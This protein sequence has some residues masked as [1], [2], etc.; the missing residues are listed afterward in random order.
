MGGLLGRC[1]WLWIWAL[2]VF[3]AAKSFA[4]P[5]GVHLEHA[6]QLG[7]GFIDSE[8]Q[9]AALP[10]PTPGPDHTVYGYLAYWADDLDTVPWDHLS[11]IAL[12]TAGTTDQGALT[13]TSRWGDISGALEYAA[14]YDVKVHLTVA[15]FSTS[16]LTTLLG[17]A[18]SR[19]RLINELVEAVELHGVDGVNVDFEGMP[20]S[21]REEMVQFVADLDARV[22]EVVLATPSVDWSDAWDYKTLA[23]YS[24][25]FIMGYGYHWS[26]SAYAG[27]VDP[28]Y[29]GGPWSSYC[30]TETAGDYLASGANPDR[31]IMGLP[32]Y[33]N[34]WPTADNSVPAASEGTG[35]SIVWTQAHAKAAT[36]GYDFESV[37]RTPYYFDG[38]RQGWYP[39]ASS[40]RERIE[41]MLE[42]GLGGIGFWAL[43]YDG[44]DEELWDGVYAETT[45][46]LEPQDTGE[47]SG[48]YIA[49]AGIPFL[50]YV[51]DTVVLSGEWST[52]PEPI[53]FQWS[54]R[55]GPEVSLSQTDTMQPT[56]QV[57][58][59]GTHVFS[60]SLG[61][62][63]TVSSMARS[64]VVVMDR[65]IGAQRYPGCGCMS[66]SWSYVGF[67]TVFLGVFGVIRRRREMI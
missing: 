31:I 49:N 37:S 42:M 62:G 2:G 43:N 9:P 4:A 29:G 22:D 59:A 11:H 41:V 65:E 60:L 38:E 28:L 5:V 10:P 19:D 6:T 14:T 52:G 51:G 3:V 32:L 23:E 50:A 55:S 40:T 39:N 17:S 47:T 13:N 26:G 53:V 25:L 66:T 45:D 33:G 18:S 12:F 64:Y 20:S 46:E 57:M 7:A 56:F 67:F 54:Q 36:H 8:R 34:H 24:D 30:L 27:P 61:D 44:Q 63:E 48:E 58:E 21:R 16:E 1:G 35:Q 15:N